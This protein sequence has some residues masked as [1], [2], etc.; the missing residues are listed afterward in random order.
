MKAIIL[1][2][3]LA[4][5]SA[6]GG[7]DSISDKVDMKASQSP[8]S[9]DDMATDMKKGCGRNLDCT[10]LTCPNGQAVCLQPSIPPGGERF[11][12]CR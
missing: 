8:T 5:A 11:C 6:C 3:G 12:S 1:Y 2:L 7:D 4:L 9:G 10:W